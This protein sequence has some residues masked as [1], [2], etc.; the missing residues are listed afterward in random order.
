MRTDHCDKCGAEV[1]ALELEEDPYFRCQRCVEN[2]E[3]S[4]EGPFA[5]E[6]PSL[7]EQC[8]RAWAAKEGR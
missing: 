8:R 3:S 1:P 2:W 6:G 4:Q 7:D 5:S